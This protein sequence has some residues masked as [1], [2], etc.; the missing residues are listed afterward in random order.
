[1]ASAVNLLFIRILLRQARANEATEAEAQTY[2]ET[3]ISGHFAT[4]KEGDSMLISSTMNGKSISF[5]AP[6]GASKFDVMTA[7]ELALEH[8]EAGIDP[9]SEAFMRH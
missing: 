8:L 9:T 7:A 3:L 2:L 5:S 4:A 1:M 6:P